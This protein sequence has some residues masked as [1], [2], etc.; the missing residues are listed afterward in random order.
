M[1]GLISPEARFSSYANTSPFGSLRLKYLHCG[2]GVGTLDAAPPDTPRGLSDHGPGP[3]QRHPAQAEQRSIGWPPPSPTV[4]A[5]PSWMLARASSTT[6]A[7]GALAQDVVTSALVGVGADHFGM[8]LQAFAAAVETAE[9]RANSR[10]GRDIVANLPA[11]LPQE[12]QIA[13]LTR[14]GTAIS[15]RYQ[16]PCSVS[17]HRAD[18]RGDDPERP[19]PHL[20]RHP[21]NPSRRHVRPEDSNP[22]RPE[23][24]SGGDHRAADPCTNTSPT[25]RSNAPASNSGST[26]AS[27]TSTPSTVRSRSRVSGE[28]LPRRNAAPP[29]PRASTSKA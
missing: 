5:S 23:D 16:T 4:P 11:E 22:R 26:S 21:S 10:I 25:R 24:R 12:Q 18:A 19:R 28:Q 3:V 29:S 1:N 8:D 20:D 2:Q 17:F 7:G 15:E 6:T 14:M 27:A 13:L 9:T